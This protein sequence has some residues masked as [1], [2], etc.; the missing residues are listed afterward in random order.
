MMAHDL[1]P[2]V[3]GIAK[4]Y[5]DLLDLLIVDPED[6]SLQSEIEKLGVKPVSA[7]IRMNSLANKQRLARQV[8]ALLLK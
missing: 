2:S 6:Q 4:A 3:T 7:D 5:A 1:E 8:L